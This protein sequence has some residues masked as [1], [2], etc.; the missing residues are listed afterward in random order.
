M[1]R[2]SPVLSPDIRQ[3]P[4]DL[5][6]SQRQAGSHSRKSTGREPRAAKGRFLRIQ[7]QQRDA[8]ALTRPLTHGIVEAFLATSETHA[9]FA[10]WLAGAPGFEPGI[11]GS[12]PDA[13]TAW[14]RPIVCELFL[15]NLDGGAATRA[16]AS[17][18]DFPAESVQAVAALEIPAPEVG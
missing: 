14:L 11:T 6:R 17:P 4:K 13:L 8:N 1:P 7:R 5:V 18:G 3:L 15:Y 12:K 9:K 10:D 2:G 16:T